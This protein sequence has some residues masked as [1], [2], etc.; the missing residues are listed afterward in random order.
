MPFSKEISKEASLQYA[1]LSYEEGNPFEAIGGVLD[2]FIKDYPEAPQTAQL[3]ELLLNAFLLEKNYQGALDL[4][5]KMPE[6]SIPS[7]F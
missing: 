2:N 1:K 6:Q 3:K 4:A 5:V 7:L